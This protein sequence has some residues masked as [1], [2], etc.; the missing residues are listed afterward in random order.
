VQQ[1]FRL[2][3]EI[4]ERH[5]AVQVE[6]SMRRSTAGA[7]DALQRGEIDAAFGNVDDV[8]RPVPPSVARR[9]VSYERI[10]A[11]ASVDHPLARVPEVSHADLARHVMWWPTDDAAPERRRWVTRFA[12]RHRIVL[13]VHGGDL[14]AEHLVHDLVG[15]PDR[16]SLYGADWPLPAGAPVR[17]VPIVDPIPLYPWSLLWLPANTHPML[18]DLLAGA[19]P[20]AVPEGRQHVWTGV[21]DP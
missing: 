5:D 9:R 1:P 7:L 2:V 20:V 8:D 19:P 3:R 11:I 15:N 6:V 21:T 13:E 10:H 4:V 12:R 14:G 16:L 17:L 18:P